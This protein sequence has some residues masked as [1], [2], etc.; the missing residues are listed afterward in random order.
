MTRTGACSEVSTV[1]GARLGLDQGLGLRLKRG[2][3]PS[4]GFGLE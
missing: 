3:G 1:A 2:P 4:F